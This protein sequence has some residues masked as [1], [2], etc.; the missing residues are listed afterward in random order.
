MNKK[1][2]IIT[3]S[4]LAI[5]GAG[6]GFYFYTRNKNKNNSLAREGVE[7][8]DS[9]ATTT[10]QSTTT[11]TSSG[12]SGKGCG[13]AYTKQGFPLQKGSCGDNV[14]KLQKYLGITADGKF[15]SGTEKKL[16][17]HQNLVVQK[18]I[19]WSAGYG[20]LSQ[21]DFNALKL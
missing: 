2:I 5:I 4:S 17:S 3:V 9:E 11:P 19:G 18:S 1:A 21:A 15:G 10:P 12:N 8:E 7:D 13:G 16:K 20:K 14:V 6:V